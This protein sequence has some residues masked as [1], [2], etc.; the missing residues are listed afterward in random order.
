MRALW[1]CLIFLAGGSVAQA[2][3]CYLSETGK[4]HYQ[5]MDLEFCDAETCLTFTK[6]NGRA[7]REVMK[8]Y[9]CGGRYCMYRSRN[10]QLVF[11]AAGRGTEYVSNLDGDQVYLICPPR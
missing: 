11:P 3:T 9:A 4:Q 7:G 1:L 5:A 2:S 8:F 10:Y 6:L